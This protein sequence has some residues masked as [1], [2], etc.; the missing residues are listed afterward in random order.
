MTAALGINDRV[1]ETLGKAVQLDIM[2]EVVNFLAQNLSILAYGGSSVAK[3]QTRGSF[4][5]GHMVRFEVGIPASVS[6]FSVDFCGV[7]SLLALI[8][9]TWSQVFI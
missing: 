6:G 9:L 1:N 7:F 2:S 5:M 8:D 3:T 4:H